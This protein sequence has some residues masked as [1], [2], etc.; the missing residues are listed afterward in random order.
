MRWGRPHLCRPA[1]SRVA[2]LPGAI[3]LKGRKS[4]PKPIRLIDVSHPARAD[5]D[6]DLVGTYATARLCSGG[7]VVS[8]MNRPPCTSAGEDA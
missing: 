4:S 5:R 8:P 3:E 2:T 7:H 1:P 6:D